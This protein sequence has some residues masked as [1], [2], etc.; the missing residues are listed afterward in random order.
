MASPPAPRIE[1]RWVCIATEKQVALAA[2]VAS[3]FQEEG[4]YLAVF[5]FPPIDVPSSSVNEAGTDGYLARLIG[6][7]AAKS[8]ER[9][10]LGSS[11]SIGSGSSAYP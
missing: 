7:R 1:E 4:A 9:N 10:T 8:G 5:E 2:V 11:S 6:D 3:Y